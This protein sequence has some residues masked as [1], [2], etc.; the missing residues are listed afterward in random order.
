VATVEQ[1][2][3]EFTAFLQIDRVQTFRYAVL[4]INSGADVAGGAE[5]KL[6]PDG[7]GGLRFRFESAD[8]T[9]SRVIKEGSSTG[10]VPVGST[11]TVNFVHTA[12]MECYTNGEQRTLSLI[13]GALATW[14]AP[15]TGSTFLGAF[16]SG[17][18]SSNGLDVLL[19]EWLM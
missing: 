3:W 8:S 1:A 9:P 19:G 5:C 14:P 6:A 11:V 15:A 12:D 13:S 18:A 2:T 7:A 17:G 10:Q 4:Q 16:V